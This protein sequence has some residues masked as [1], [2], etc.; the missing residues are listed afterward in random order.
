MLQEL[1]QALAA[2]FESF[3]VLHSHVTVMP[4]LPPV[5]GPLL[6]ASGIGKDESVL[7]GVMLK[8]P[9]GARPR[10]GHPEPVARGRV[11]E[12]N[13]G[14]ELMLAVSRCRTHSI[15]VRSE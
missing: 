9:I 4:G 11:R 2:L 7:P 13:R 14:T 15:G 10:E 6:F 3:R 1:L 5:A 12:I 8:P